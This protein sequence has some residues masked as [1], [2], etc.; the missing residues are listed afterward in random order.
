VLR[1]PGVSSDDVASVTIGTTAFLNAVLERDARHLSRVA[2]IRLSKSFLRD[3]KPFADWPTDLRDVLNGYVGYVDGGLHI[4]GSE[5]APILE[6]QILRECAE[7]KKRGIK[8]IV[9][10]GIFSPIDH[11]FKQEE[12]VRNMIAREIEGADIVCSRD[13]ANIGES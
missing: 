1:Q 5:E 9:I 10:A 2:V 7:I 13:V 3:V 11:S 8:A 6:Q 4:D 12:R